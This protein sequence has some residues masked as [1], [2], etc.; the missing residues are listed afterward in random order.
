M[1][2]PTIPI[3]IVQPFA[4]NA[5]T[6]LIVQV[7]ETTTT[8]GRASYDA[9]FPQPTFDPV[10]SGGN[11]PYGSDFNGLFNQ[12]SAWVRWMIAGGAVTY[13]SAFAASIYVNG[14]PIGAVLN[15]TDGGWW[16]NLVDGNTTDPDAGGAGWQLITTGEVVTISSPGAAIDLTTNDSTKDYVTEVNQAFNLPTAADVNNGVCFGFNCRGGTAMLTPDP[17][18]G[19]GGGPAGQA[20]TFPDG[21]GGLVVR[22]DTGNWS[23]LYFSGPGTGIY[24]NASLVISPGNTYL[25]DSR[26][27]SFTLT[28]PV[29]STSPAS[30][31]F[32]DVGK[33]TTVNPVTLARNGGTIGGLPEDCLINL[34]GVEFG[35][36]NDGDTT[37]WSIL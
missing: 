30:I 10:A 8:I 9:G 17:A 18:A 31:N 20:Y 1:P 19:V 5:P 35:T 2:A 12:I 27:G 22:D 15:R 11:P 24:V 14:Y 21:T 29:T 4:A 13:D 32:K 28:M 23:I 25:I 37:D 3:K 26:A 6:G 33:Y 16:W 7:P 34:S 36:T